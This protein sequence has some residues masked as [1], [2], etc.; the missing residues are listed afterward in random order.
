MLRPSP[1]TPSF[2]VE[3]LSYLSLC[4]VLSVSLSDLIM[5]T[6]AQTLPSSTTILLNT[7]TR[8]LEG[9]AGFIDTLQSR[10]YQLLD[11]LTAASTTSNTWFLTGVTIHGEFPITRTQNNR[12]TPISSNHFTSFKHCMDRSFMYLQITRQF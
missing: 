6:R 5:L 1:F 4:L 9:F 11:S 10:M 7:S 2:P 8:V 3:P 12:T